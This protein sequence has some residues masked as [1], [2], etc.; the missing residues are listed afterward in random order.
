M[1][2]S[3]TSAMATI[4]TLSQPVRRFSIAC[5]PR[6]PQPISPAFSF[7]LPAPRTNSGLMI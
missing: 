1:R 3:K 2:S 5:V 4:S 7:S 6:P